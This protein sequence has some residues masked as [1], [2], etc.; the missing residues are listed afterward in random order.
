MEEIESLPR[1][2]G[3]R[4][5][6]FNSHNQLIDIEFIRELGCGRHS[7]TWEV[8]INRNP[9]ALKIVGSI[10]YVLT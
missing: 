5:H 9:F 2:P 3:P 10:Q 8:L 7:K 1:I 4:L 6:Q